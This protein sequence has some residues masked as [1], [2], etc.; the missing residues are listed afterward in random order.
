MS[1]APPDSAPAAARDLDAL[2][3]RLDAADGG[4]ELRPLG[5]GAV[6][7]GRGV[8]S[9]VA[10]AVAELRTGEGPVIMIADRRPM[11]GP[12]GEVKTI[13]AA[14]ITHAGLPLVRV[15]VGDTRAETHADAAT[16]DAATAQSARACVLVSVGSGTVVDIGKAVSAALGGVPHVVVQTAASVNGFADDQSVLLREGVKRT[17][18][19][20]WPDRLLVDT[21]VIAAAPAELNRAGLG[22]LL[23]TY[24]A[25][26]DWL[27][28]RLVG[29][30]DSY[31]AT[32]VGL[33]RAHVDAVLEHAG[34]IATGDP[35]AIDNLTASL[36]LSGISMG[37]AGRTAPGSGMEHT[38]S[39]LLE[40]A[41]QPGDPDVLHGAQVGALSVLGAMLWTR[42]RAA[43]RNG[44]L[45]NLRFPEPVQLRSRVLAA[46][47]D[48][49][50]SG[51]MGTECWR[52]YARKLE[53]WHGAREQLADLPARWPA[54][55]AELDGLLADPERLVA[56]LRAA[57]APVRL[58]ELG[59]GADTARWALS[60]SH[61]MRD[62]FTV[63][64]LAFFMGIWEAAHAD[65]LLAQAA[66]LGAGL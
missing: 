52:D 26:A 5:L 42:V 29:Q 43:A 6:L 45:E 31:S 23:A 13:V 34:A 1:I 32:V 62:R 3:A 14:A 4:A 20:R 27:L 46:F 7:L 10:P 44:G 56:A 41:R 63:A 61:L 48:L 54:F 51:R 22:D 36:T 25:P 60:N 15:T 57:D 33:A 47:E 38:V 11:A 35:D 58:S 24:T 12:G 59:I 37:V 30:D 9:Q 50:P 64:D 39:H 16:I 28:A 65:A 49:D 21:D 17:T 55:D 40:M 18:P 19:T 2:R 66:A 53:R 8:L